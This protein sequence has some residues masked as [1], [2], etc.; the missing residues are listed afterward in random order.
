M[1]YWSADKKGH[2]YV[3]HFFSPALGADAPPAQQTTQ[4]SNASK[5]YKIE[6]DHDGSFFSRLWI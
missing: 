3:N 1:D 5:L 4:Y 6:I 2:Q